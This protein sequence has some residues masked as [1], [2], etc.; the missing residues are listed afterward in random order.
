[1]WVTSEPLGTAEAKAALRRAVPQLDEFLA[2]G[3]IEILDCREWYTYLGRFDG[4]RVR[5]GWL[6]KLEAALRRMTESRE[7]RG[8]PPTLRP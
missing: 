5:Q 8:W 7:A 4:D 6:D 3:Q 2:N 1:M